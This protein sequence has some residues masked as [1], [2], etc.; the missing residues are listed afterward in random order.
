[1]K[2]VNLFAQDVLYETILLNL[3]LIL[4]CS[5]AKTSE[6]MGENSKMLNLGKSMLHYDDFVNHLHDLLTIVDPKCSLM[7]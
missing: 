2:C 3:L 4:N 7:N 5:V 6:G 1:M